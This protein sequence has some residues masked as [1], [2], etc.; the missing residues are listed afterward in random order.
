MSES[1][2]IPARVLAV[3]FGAVWVL[4]GSPARAKLGEA[5]IDAARSD[6]RAAVVALLDQKADVNAREDDGTTSLAWAATRSNTGIAELLLK[7]GAN[8][9]LTNEMGIGSSVIGDYEW[10]DG[11]CKA[12]DREGRRSNV[13][14]ENGETPLMTAARLG[15]LEVMKLLLDRRPPKWTLATRNSARQP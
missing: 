12:S 5:L 15:Q 11:Y 6:D 7:A 3:G 9:D 2:S 8:P 13:A 1:L 14:R 10:F 4:A